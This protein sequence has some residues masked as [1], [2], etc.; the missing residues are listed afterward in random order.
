M[1]NRD[2]RSKQD[3]AE[4]HLELAK[5]EFTAGEMVSGTVHLQVNKK[6]PA[7]TVCLEIS[8][9]E[10]TKWKSRDGHGSK[11]HTRSHTGENVVLLS[12]SII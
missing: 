6:Y 4:M 10:K 12:R 1:G 9:K 5:Q 11:R 2:S 8:G 7:R 3:Y